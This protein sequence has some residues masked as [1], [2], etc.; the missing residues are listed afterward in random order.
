MSR[1][2]TKLTKAAAGPS[3]QHSN[4]PRDD[5]NSRL[6]S[7]NADIR[8]VENDIANRQNYLAELLETRDATLNEIR[9]SRRTRVPDKG[10]A[11]QTTNTVDYMTESFEWSGQLQS[12]MKKV[13]GINDFR[14][15]QKGSAI[16]S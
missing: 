6:A 15:C 10:K 12:R 8:Q 1:R 13:F 4:P 14:F 16:S 3:T 7:I 11:K 5:L 2:E 9:S